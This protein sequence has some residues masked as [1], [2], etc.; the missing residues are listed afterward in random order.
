VCLECTLEG[1]WRYHIDS[2]LIRNKVWQTVLAVW[3]RCERTR[4]WGELLVI[5][6][7][8][9]VHTENWWFVLSYY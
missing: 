7:R 3:P 1:Y 6:E 4:C 2:W 5:G 9:K 8:R